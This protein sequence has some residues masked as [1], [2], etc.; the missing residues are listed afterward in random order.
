MLVNFSVFPV[1][2]GESLS[3]QVKEIIE[4]IDSSGLS[5]RLGAMGTTVE[6]EWDEV[7]SVVKKCH[8]KLREKNRRV[9]LV[10]TVDDREGAES[11]LEGKIR[12]IEEKAGRKYRT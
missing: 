12:S 8:Y 11:R 3:G 1:G 5:Y 10:M 7:M 2:A 9:Y 6:G 4:I